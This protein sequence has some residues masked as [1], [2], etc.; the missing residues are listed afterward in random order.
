MKHTWWVWIWI[1]L[2]SG[3]VSQQGKQDAKD[4]KVDA[5]QRAV[6]HTELGAAYSE[7]GQFAVAI[8][9]LKEAISANPNYAPAHNQLGL[10]YM[11]LNEN[12]LARQSFERALKID[13]EDSATNNNYGTFLCQRTR[14]KDVMRYFLTALKNPLYATPEIASTNAGICARMQ[15]DEIKAEEWLRK[16]ISLQPAQPQALYLLADISFRK[17]DLLNARGFLT[18]HLQASS[19]TVESLWLGARIENQLGDRSALTSYGVQL[20]N[21]FPAAAQTRAFNERQFK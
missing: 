16:A 17:G 13:P 19:P 20:N 18:R 7:V 2:I 12:Q 15:G 14:E 1:G 11:A 21:R 3:C 4:A 9:E 10:A 8:E 6:A 5:L